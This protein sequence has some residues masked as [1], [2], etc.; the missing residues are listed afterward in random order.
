[1][2]RTGSY[3]GGNTIIKVYLPRSTPSKNAGGALSRWI[4]D[5]RQ[6]QERALRPSDVVRSQAERPTGSAVKRFKKWSSQ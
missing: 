6:Q 5:Y 3:S 1:M 4:E 2:S